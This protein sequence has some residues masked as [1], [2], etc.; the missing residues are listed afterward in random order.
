MKPDPDALFLLAALLSGTACALS[1]SFATVNQEKSP[2]RVLT[3][4]CG[5]GF[6]IRPLSCLF[7]EKMQ[8]ST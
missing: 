7:G 5:N 1:K 6:Y 4:F 2:V 3:G 8:E